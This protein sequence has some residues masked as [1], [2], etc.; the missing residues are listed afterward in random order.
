L[1]LCA[2]IDIFSPKLKSIA[3]L[4]QA[5]QATWDNLPST[6]LLK[7]FLIACVK[8]GGGHF[9]FSQSLTN[10]LLCCSNDIVFFLQRKHRALFIRHTFCCM[11]IWEMTMSSQ[12]K[13]NNF[14]VVAD[15]E[16][17]FGTFTW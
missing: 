5:L 6:T 2:F 12:K 16:M 13:S 9:E 10:C 4:K 7:T 14:V 3:E 1:H 15:N 8:A 11:W 17:P